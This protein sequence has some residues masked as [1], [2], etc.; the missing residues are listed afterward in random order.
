MTV[1]GTVTI[2]LKDFAAMQKEMERAESLEKRMKRMKRDVTDIIEEYDDEDMEQILKK[3]DESNMT[4]KQVA[5]AYQEAVGKLKITVSAQALKKLLRKY[6]ETG[7]L[8]EDCN[9]DVK[10]A[11]DVALEQIEVKLKG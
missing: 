10:N 2:S 6:I 5:K 8:E 1:E 7:K 4:D 9:E 3:I 11:E